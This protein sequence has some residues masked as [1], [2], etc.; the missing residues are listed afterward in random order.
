MAKNNINITLATALNKSELQLFIGGEFITAY[1]YDNGKVI[2]S[3]ITG[4]V[5]ISLSE[6][7]RNIKFISI[8]V[9]QITK[10]LT[11]DTT[12]VAETFEKE[13]KKTGTRVTAKFER[14]ELVTSSSFDPATRIF[15]FTPRNQVTINFKDFINWFEF[16]NDYFK[17]CIDF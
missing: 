11:L 13:I 3:E 7:K 4:T 17:N 10:L 6:L 8:W 16:L 5:L 2:L 12:L 9:D 15:T 14:D 1:S